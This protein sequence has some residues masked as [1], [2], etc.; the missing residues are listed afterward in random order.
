MIYT[1]NGEKC[2][3]LSSRNNDELKWEN[4]GCSSNEIIIIIGSSKKRFAFAGSVS[5]DAFELIGQL[6]MWLS[7]NLPRRILQGYCADDADIIRVIPN[8]NN[9]HHMSCASSRVS[10]CGKQSPETAMHADYGFLFGE[11]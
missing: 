9:N 6:S 3:I 2:K 8:D 5:G 7:G 11:I 10:C 4:I 1:R